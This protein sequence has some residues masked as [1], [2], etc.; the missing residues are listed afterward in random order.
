[1]Y[2]MKKLIAFCLVALCCSATFAHDIK[3]VYFPAKNPKLAKVADV[4]QQGRLLEKFGEIVGALADWPSPLA[5]IVGAQCEQEN[6]FYRSDK[7]IIFLCYELVTG[8]IE[9]LPK[10]PRVR[11]LPADKQNELVTGALVAIVLH[12]SAHAMIDLFDLPTLGSEEDVADRL[13]TYLMLKHDLPDGLLGSVLFYSQDRR[14]FY[15][16]TQKSMA[17][18]HGLN[19]QRSINI[20]CWAYGKDPNR[21]KNLAAM[22]GLTESRASR[23]EREY[24]QLEKAITTLLGVR[25]H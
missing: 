3:S 14:I 1:M 18:E 11:S 20:A 15:I 10:D 21:Y 23:C 4:L 6:A 2:A 5:A 17:D 9:R 12:E 7:K 19:P 8:I 16:N 13:A 22:A 24:L 25:L